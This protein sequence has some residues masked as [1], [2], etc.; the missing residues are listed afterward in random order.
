MNEQ[1]F[2]TLWIHA[3]T[4]NDATLV[5]LLTSQRYRP[6]EWG[7][8]LVDVVLTLSTVNKDLR[9]QLVDVI[10]K[11]PP[12]PINVNGTQ[13]TFVPDGAWA[14]DYPACYFNSDGSWKLDDC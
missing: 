9:D 14:S 8:F 1:Q 4:S 13:Y 5:A 12:A 7:D 11:Q 2:H 6:K 3:T 10:S